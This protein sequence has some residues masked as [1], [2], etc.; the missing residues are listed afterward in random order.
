MYLS[1]LMLNPRSRQVRRDLADCHN[2]HRTILSAFPQATGTPDQG[3]RDQ[4]AVLHRV[5]VNQ[6]KGEVTLLVQSA[7]EPDWTKLAPGYLSDSADTKN[8]DYKRVDEQYDSLTDG[9]TLSFRLRANPTRKIDTKSLPDGTR[10]N[11]KRVELRKQEE[12]L[13]WLQR[14]ARDCGFHVNSVRINRDVPNM[15]LID[16]G[17]S[18]GWRADAEGGAKKKPITFNSV[19]FEGELIVEDSQ[20]FRRAL[21][22]GIGSAKAYGFGL[23]SI[24]AARS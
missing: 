20:L 11:G 22:N 23:L 19:L 3:A 7:A 24:A 16:E 1:R 9:M 14:K 17:K 6:R 4:F 5:D 15:R 13:A 21:E 2:L 10:R 8:P 12:L 18:T